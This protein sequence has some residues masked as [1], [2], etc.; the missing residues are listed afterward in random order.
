MLA[1]TALFPQIMTIH[2]HQ[3]KTG[4][5]FLNFRS[6]IQNASPQYSFVELPSDCLYAES[7]VISFAMQV[8]GARD[9]NVDDQAILAVF[10]KAIQE[11]DQSAWHTIWN[12]YHPVIAR[13]L[14][15]EL[16][17]W[18]RNG[19]EIRDIVQTVFIKFWEDSQQW[20]T[21]DR[22]Y[23]EGKQ[24]RYP[25]PPPFDRCVHRSAIPPE[26][27]SEMDTSDSPELPVLPQSG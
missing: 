16:T 11:K 24:G 5:R 13:K 27:G 15:R 12:H 7:V 1:Q 3:W 6:M 2:P 23:S 20:K 4:S 9:I 17:G 8:Y 21:I 10:R 19:E 25:E 26:A 22:L 18:V 14:Q